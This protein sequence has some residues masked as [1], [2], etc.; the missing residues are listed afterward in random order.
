VLSCDSEGELVLYELPAERAATTQ[1]TAGALSKTGAAAPA[2]RP[3]AI[4]RMKVNPTVKPVLMPHRKVIV[5]AANEKLRFFD[6]LSILHGPLAEGADRNQQFA[7][8]RRQL[9]VDARRNRREDGAADEAVAF[10]AAQR[11]GQHLLRDAADRTLDLAEALGAITEVT[12]DQHRPFIAD[13]RQYHAHP[14]AFLGEVKVTRFQNSASLSGAP[15]VVTYA[16]PVTIP[17]SVI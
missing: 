1:A 17:Y 2:A 7:A 16:L 13:A 8:E 10:E 3:K 11:R 4:Y 6:A 12:H 15:I 14:P 5:A 9:I